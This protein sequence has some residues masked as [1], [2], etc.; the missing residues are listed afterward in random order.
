[1]NLSLQNSKQKFFQKGRL[2]IMLPVVFVNP[3]FVN[4]MSTVWFK[5]NSV[6]LKQT[7]L[8]YDQIFSNATARLHEFHLA[9][10]FTA[11]TNSVSTAIIFF[12]S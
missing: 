10:D 4:P 6:R 11:Q 3:M 8:P 2:Q 5:R 9:A 7:S 1:M 12:Q